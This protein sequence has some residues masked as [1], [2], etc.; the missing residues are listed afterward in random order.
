MQID[1]FSLQSSLD[2]LQ[3]RFPC[4]RAAFGSVAILE[5]SGACIRTDFAPDYPALWYGNITQEC[6][7]LLFQK[8][9]HPVKRSSHKHDRKTVRKTTVMPAR[10]TGESAHG[11]QYYPEKNKDN[12]S[13]LRGPQNR[14]AEKSALP[15]GC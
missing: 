6:K 4:G 2:L 5:L 8:R 3:Q 9:L 15:Y 11:W 12:M 14:G 7:T 10:A 1:F 13:C